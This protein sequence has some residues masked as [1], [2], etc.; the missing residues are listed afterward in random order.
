MIVLRV[1]RIAALLGAIAIASGCATDQDEA[2]YLGLAA[3]ISAASGQGVH[4]GALLAVEEINHTGGVNG[5]PLELDPRDDQMDRERAIEIATRFRDEGNVAAVI[6]HL[7]SGATVAA[8][9][10]YNDPED[11]LLAIS[12]GATS[13]ELSGIGEWTFRV[14]PS[15]MHQGQAL[16]EWAHGR[17]GLRRAA[18]IYEND[19]YGRGVLDAFAPAF[20]ELGGTIIAQDPFLASIIETENT[21]DPYIERAIH[22]GMDALIIAGLGDEL[23]DILSAARRLGFR[24]TIMGPDGLVDLRDAGP[25]ADGVVMTSGFLPDRETTAAREFVQKYVD[26]FGE[27]PRDGSAH[28][29]DTVMLLANAIREV[30]NDRRAIR[31]YIAKVGSDHPAHEGVTGTIRFDAAGDAEGKDV[32]IGI[33]EDGQIRAAR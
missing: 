25:I 27:T 2:I 28:A 12:P 15:D 21:L 16:A 32:D 19:Q 5:Y 8:A 29:Y 23:V 6:G 14:C 17:L 26:R 3:P 7:S 13:P 33:I 1:R 22:N 24:G 31:D 11:G 9:H 30:G 4:Q 10:I 18:V 20:E